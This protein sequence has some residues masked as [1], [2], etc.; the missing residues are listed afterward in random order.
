[1][2][3]LLGKSCGKRAYLDITVGSQVA[4]PGKRNTSTS[5]SMPKPT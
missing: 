5:I 3:S 1:M 4:M 2:G